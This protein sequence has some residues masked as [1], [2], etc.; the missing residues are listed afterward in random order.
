MWVWERIFDDLMQHLH[1]L[2]LNIDQCIC[3]SVSMCVF[4]GET[5]RLALTACQTSA[6]G[7]PFP[8]L[9]NWWVNITQY[10][11]V[12]FS[13]WPSLRLDSF[14]SLN[15][16]SLLYGQKHNAQKSSADWQI[17]RQ[18]RDRDTKSCY[19][20]I[21]WVILEVILECLIWQLRYKIVV[22]LTPYPSISPLSL[23]QKKNK[24]L[25]F[26]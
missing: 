16:V 20:L 11:I 1:F 6:R 23:S 14:H 17:F 10:Q 8:L 2:Y 3:L 26:E 9:V 15:E 25:I 22:M 12:D 7:G 13:F 24:S 5:H 4:T 18:L 19:F 21:H